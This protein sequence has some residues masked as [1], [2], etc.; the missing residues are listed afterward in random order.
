[1]ELGRGLSMPQLS[2]FWQAGL[3]GLSEVQSAFQPSMAAEMVVMRLCYLAQM[4]DP[5]SLIAQMRDAGASGAPPPGDSGPRVT[6]APTG[7]PVSASDSAPK[8]PCPPKAS[9]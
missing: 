1:M 5:S 7:A 8:A 2:R 3:A 4:P 9:D 6:L